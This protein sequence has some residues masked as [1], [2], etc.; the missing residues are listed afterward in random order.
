MLVGLNRLP[1]LSRARRDPSAGSSL[2]LYVWSVLAGLLVPLLVILL[3]LI[4]AV[5]NTQGLGSSVKLGNHLRVPVPRWLYSIDP[6][7]Q[8]TTMVVVAFALA[9]AFSMV[10]WLHRRSADRRSRGIARNLHASLLNQS[11]RRAEIEG[12][13]AQQ[14][15]AVE[16]IGTDLPRLQDGLSLW[17]RVLP[18]SVLTLLA[19]IALA[20]LVNPWLT[21]VAVV[22]G[23][24]L[25]KW[26]LGLSRRDDDEMSLWDIDRCRTAMA[27]LVGRGPL[28]AR[29]QTPGLTGRAFEAQTDRLYRLLEAEDRKSG[30]VWPLVFLAVTAAVAIL[31]LG[32]G[33]N[34]FQTEN[35]LRLP[36]VVVLALALGATTAA[37]SRLMALAEQLKVSGDA[38]DRIFSYLR[39][40]GELAPSE[41][42][43][44]LA[45]VRD[46]VVI[47][48]VSLYDSTG[49][50]ILENLSLSLRPGTLVAVLGTDDVSVRAL[51]ELLMGFG[52]PS[53]G[54]VAIDGIPLRDIHPRALADNVM[55]IEPDGPI[56]DGTILDNVRG[57]D[58]S[59]HNSDVVEALQKLDVYERLHRMPDG[60]STIVTSTE[61]DLGQEATYAIAVARAS[62]HRVPIVLVAEPTAPAEHLGDDPALKTF[63]EMAAR[64][65]IV[66]ML[67]RRLPSLREADRVVL[68]N[69]PRMAGEGDHAT[70]LAES[71]L[72]RHLNYLLFNPYRRRG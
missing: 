31:I 53:E 34:S 21:V 44:G 60:L 49:S 29:L 19:C 2:G 66:V 50:A 35:T 52:S 10:V 71:D 25:W 11:M 23:Y 14:V 22:T 39:Q 63:R 20:L 5:L 28:L 54:R 70:L 30:R 37:V 42:R 17:Y 15:R 47:E 9:A 65:A 72:Y 51:A 57:E 58:E 62:V 13:A 45:G 12:A 4:A 7:M 38:S 43:V 67:P 33:V 46:G 1:T 27:D 48:G 69:G 41:Q 64:G 68:L 24:F 32:M 8:L 61:N 26:L 18:R 40:I 3:G 36:S 55:W 59:I 16:L 6:L 56:W